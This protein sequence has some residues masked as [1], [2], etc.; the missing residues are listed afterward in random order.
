M[1]I[2]IDYGMGNLRSV[3]K[4]VEAL[5]GNARVSDSPVDLKRASKIIFPG[6]GHFGAA[7]SQLKKRKL[8]QVIKGKI[9]DGTFFL[10]I[11]LGMQLLFERS[12][13]APAVAGLGLVPGTVRLFKGAGLSVPHMGWNQVEKTIDQRPTRKVIKGSPAEYSQAGRPE[14]NNLFKGVP[15]NSYFYFAHSYYCV[16]QDKK[17]IAAVTVHGKHFASAINQNNIWAVQF[18]PEKSQ[19]LGLKVLNNFLKL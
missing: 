2:I 19:D 13:E 18:H 9:K 15:Q 16:P 5:G 6:V 11:C 10:G 17:N 8:F 1:I 7:V 3:A 14:T 12:E 4:A